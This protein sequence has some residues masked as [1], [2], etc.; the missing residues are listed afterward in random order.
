MSDYLAN[1]SQVSPRNAPRLEEKLRGNRM[2]TAIEK[3]MI[4]QTLSRH[5]RRYLTPTEFVVLSYIVDRS[6]GWGRG[7]FVACGDNVLYGD[8]EYAGVGVGR[9]AYYNSLRSLEAAGAISRKSHRDRT[10]IWLHTNWCNF[11]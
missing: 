3:L 7:D 4:Y 10:R 8:R 5:W 11:E 1:V 6:A 2:L 9:T